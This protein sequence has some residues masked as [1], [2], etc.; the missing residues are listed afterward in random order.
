MF[1][2]DSSSCLRGY[3]D[4]AS[5]SGGQRIGR[6]CE[7]ITH[8]MRSEVC[9]STQFSVGTFPRAKLQPTDVLISKYN[10][11][12]K[13]YKTPPAP[14]LSN[15]LVFLLEEVCS[16]EHCAQSWN[17]SLSSGTPPAL[18]PSRDRSQGISSLDPVISMSGANPPWKYEWSDT[19][20]LSQLQAFIYHMPTSP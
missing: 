15:L 2:F 7:T 10:L 18:L 9:Y 19:L 8:I 4:G 5:S 14:I 13:A 3:F 16:A 11:K 20:S 17:V 1:V 6:L 12:I